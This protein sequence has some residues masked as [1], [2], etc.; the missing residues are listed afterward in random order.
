MQLGWGLELALGL[1][2]RPLG[3]ALG[4]PLAWSAAGRATRA[5][6]WTLEP[7]RQRP[8]RAA[9]LPACAQVARG[10]AQGLARLRV[11]ELDLAQ[12][13]EA[14]RLQGAAEQQA[15]RLMRT[16]AKGRR[17][18]QPG[19]AVVP[20]VRAA[21]RWFPALALGL[22]ALAVLPPVHQA[23]LRMAR[24][25]RTAAEPALRPERR[26]MEQGARLPAPA[27]SRGENQPIARR[28]QPPAPPRMEARAPLRLPAPWAA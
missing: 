2:V 7:G 15:R 19:A 10:L 18:V 11:R 17:R 6:K 1:A 5:A 24:E 21:R 26:E 25:A 23:R 16:A 20:P 12:Q 27:Q 22:R 14:K 9:L 13:R 28:F 3:R 4:R 8:G